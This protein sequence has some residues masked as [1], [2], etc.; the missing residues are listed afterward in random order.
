MVVSEKYAVTKVQLV[1]TLIRKSNNIRYKKLLF[2][3]YT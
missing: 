2:Y 3:G 1:N